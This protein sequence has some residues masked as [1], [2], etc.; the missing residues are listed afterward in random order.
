MIF[1]DF[2]PMLVFCVKEKKNCIYFEAD[3]DAGE[4]FSRQ[5]EYWLESII[6]DRPAL[7]IR[8]I[9]ELCNA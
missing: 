3:L 7:A 6:T 1:C 5:R 8:L 4:I 9:W 2:G